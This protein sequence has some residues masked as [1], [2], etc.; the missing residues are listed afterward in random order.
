MTP[1]LPLVGL[2]VG[3]GRLEVTDQ[4]DDGQQRDHAG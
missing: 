1:L 3:G 2:A 4:P